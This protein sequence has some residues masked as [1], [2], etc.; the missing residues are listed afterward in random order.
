MLSACFR[1]LVISGLVAGVAAAQPPAGISTESG[2]Y[3]L[4]KFEQPIGE[5]TFHIERTAAAVVLTDTFLFTDRGTAVPLETT[6]RAA[7]DLTPRSFESKG[8]SSRFSN[9]DVA[10]QVQGRT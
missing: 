1:V 7:A 2:T 9:V 6:F 8:K 5:E 3:R 4:F 10:M